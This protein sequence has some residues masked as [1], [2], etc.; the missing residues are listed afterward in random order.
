MPIHHDDLVRQIANVRALHGAWRKAGPA[1][2]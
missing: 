1:K 2:Q